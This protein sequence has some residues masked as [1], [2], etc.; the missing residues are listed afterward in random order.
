MQAF[1]LLNREIFSAKTGKIRLHCGEGGGAAAG[2]GLL[3]KDI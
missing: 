3:G 1:D 2:E